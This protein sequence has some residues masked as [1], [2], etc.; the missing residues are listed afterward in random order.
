MGPNL[1][2]QDA[3]HSFHFIRSKENNNWFSYVFFDL[4]VVF[5][6]TQVSICQDST[7]CQV[8]CGYGYGNHYAVV[9]IGSVQFSTNILTTSQ[10]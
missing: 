5:S 1:T 4:L 8:L 3:E 9:S 6:D 10:Y 2:F 7:F